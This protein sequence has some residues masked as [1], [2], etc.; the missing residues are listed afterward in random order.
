MKKYDDILIDKSNIHTFINKSLRIKK[1]V[2]E[3]DEFD[4]SERRKF[5][6]G[7]TFGH[8][9]E[10]I[11]NYKINHGQAVTLGMDL[12]NFISLKKSKITNKKY[13]LINSYLKKNFPNYNLAHLNIKKYLNILS[14]DKKNINNKLG[15]ILLDNHNDLNLNYLKFDQN[16]ENILIEYFK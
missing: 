14:K 12:A 6:Y 5:N 2:I 11:T 1:R 9:L 16:L 7:H 4:K 10:A 8:A 13:V 3:I 15:C